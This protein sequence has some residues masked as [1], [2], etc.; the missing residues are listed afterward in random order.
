MRDFDEFYAAHYAD[1]AV[2]VYAYFGD[3]HEAQD[4]VQDAFCRAL[5]GWARIS[6]YDDPHQWVRRVA[7]NLATSRWR[8]I[9]TARAFQ[10]RQRGEPIADGP[11]P[12]R[13]ALIDALAT[14][15]A[16]HRRAIVLHYLADLPVAEI[17]DREGVPEATVRSWLHRGRTSLAV[18]LDPADLEVPRA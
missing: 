1:L 5:A 4:V 8:R 9:R 17:A 13:V 2:Q 12:D 11:G 10:S 7:W 18:R 6:A 16:K 3:R 14:L 15:P